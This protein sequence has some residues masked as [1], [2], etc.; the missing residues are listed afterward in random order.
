MQY[1]FSVQKLTLV[2]LCTALMVVFSQI[3]IPLPFGVPITLQTFGIVLISILLEEKLASL[4]L[5]TFML[6][7]GIGLP[8]FAN[9]KGGFQMIIGPTGG[10]II[11][12]VVM[13]FITGW[14]AKSGNKFILWIATYVGLII[15]YIMGAIQLAIVVKMTF[16]QALAAGVYPF[17]I[18][19]LIL[20]AVA[21]LVASKMKVMLKGVI[22]QHVKA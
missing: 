19:D 10:F 6:L 4:A 20:T 16:H 11:G 1:K 13:A 17:I 9:F 14:G 12:F 3:A 5:F 7:G 22:G 18:K 21:I 15:D 2:S 8:V